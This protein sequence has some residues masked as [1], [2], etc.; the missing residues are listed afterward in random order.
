MSLWLF[1]IIMAVFG[2]LFTLA[3]GSVLLVRRAPVAG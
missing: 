2:V 3:G 1:P